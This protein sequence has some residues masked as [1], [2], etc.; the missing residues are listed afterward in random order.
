MIQHTFEELG[1]NQQQRIETILYVCYTPGCAATR[2]EPADPADLE[3][4][5]FTIV[6][7]NDIPAENIL[8]EWLPILWQIVEKLID[9]PE[10][11]LRI[12]DIINDE[13]YEH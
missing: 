3:I 10:T 9:K 12:K 4:Y 6:E 2:W 7:F 11:Q 8:R 13:I 5:D 1:K